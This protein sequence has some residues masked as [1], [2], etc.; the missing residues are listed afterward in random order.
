MTGDKGADTYGCVAW[1][2][3]KSGERLES[4]EVT[5]AMSKAE[6]WYGRNGSKW[7]TMPELMLRYRAATLFARLYAP[8]L[9]MGI[10]SDDEIIEIAPVVTDAPKASKARFE[11]ARDV[12]PT[13]KVEPKVSTEPEQVKEPSDPTP[14]QQN[15]TLVDQMTDFLASNNV[16]FEDFRGWLGTTG[17]YTDSDSAASMADIPET[18]LADFAQDTKGQHRVVTLYGKANQ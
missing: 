5:I 15:G 9:T 14:T 2:E 16:A 12:T 3:D 8:E 17:R 4:P 13:A 1:A 18:V 10:Q 6:G 11:R 7:K